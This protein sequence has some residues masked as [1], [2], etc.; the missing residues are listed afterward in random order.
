M[1]TIWMMK[2]IGAIVLPDRPIEHLITFYCFVFS[3]QEY[4]FRKSKISIKM[5][6]ARTIPFSPCKQL[7]APSWVNCQ[8]LA[9]QHKKHLPA[10][11]T[12]DCLAGWATFAVMAKVENVAGGGIKH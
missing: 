5:V 8:G 10:C 1:E 4:N 9:S 11:I 6:T 7:K 12:L 2:M 3:S